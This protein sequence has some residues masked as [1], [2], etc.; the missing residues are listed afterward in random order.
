MLRTLAAAALAAVLSPPTLAQSPAA[1]AAAPAATPA[2]TPAPEPDKLL[3]VEGGMLV[4]IA[5][6]YPREALARGETAVLTVSGTIQTDG[7][8]EDVRVGGDALSPSFEAEVRRSAQLWR[9]QPRIVPPLCGATETAG[10]VTVWFEIDEGK[11]KVSYGVRP[12]AAAAPAIY[13][14][15]APVRAVAPA[16]PPR[17]AANPNVPRPLRQIAYVG[18]SAAGDVI[19]VTLA[20]LLYYREFEPALSR[21]LHQWKYAPQEAPWCAELVF[22]LSPD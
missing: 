19:N 18:V 12:P 10:E 11:P 14:D 1:A 9:M 4:L 3:Y 7:R 20:P 6:S 22:F 16:Y 21:A 5:P 15:R 13:K 2:A 8:L 17:L